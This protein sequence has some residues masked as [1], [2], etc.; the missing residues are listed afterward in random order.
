MAN[1]E[2]RSA[3]ARRLAFASGSSLPFR[4]SFVIR[5]PSFVISGAFFVGAL[6]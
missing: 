2:G 3:C 1:N 4:H 6:E 5:I